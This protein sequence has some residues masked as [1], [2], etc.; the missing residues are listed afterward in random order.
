[1]QLALTCMVPSLRG[2]S[3]WPA[4]HPYMTPDVDASVSSAGQEFRASMACLQLQ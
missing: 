3:C 4:Q 2:L 1:M